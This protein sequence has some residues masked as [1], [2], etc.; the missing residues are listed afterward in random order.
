[1]DSP[2]IDLDTE[3]IDIHGKLSHLDAIDMR[4]LTLAQRY[5][6]I[7]LSGPWISDD[8]GRFTTLPGALPLLPALSRRAAMAALTA[9]EKGGLLKTWTIA[10]TK[11]WEVAGAYAF[12]RGLK[13]AKEER[14]QMAIR[15][16]KEREKRKK[17]KEDG[18]LYVPSKT[19]N[20]RGSHILIQTSRGNMTPLRQS[21]W[22]RSSVPLPKGLQRNR[23][24][25]NQPNDP[26]QCNLRLL[27]SFNPAEGLTALGAVIRH[28]L[29]MESDDYGRVRLDVHLLYDQLGRAI[30]KRNVSLETIQAELD[31][32][33]RAGYLK[34]VVKSQGRRFSFIRDSAQHLMKKKRSK[35]GIPKLMDDR[36]FTH[37][38][39]AYLAFY[40][41]CEELSISNDLVYVKTTTQGRKEMHVFEYL[42]WPRSGSWRNTTN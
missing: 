40:K 42:R 9:L 28:Y 20:S 4:E 7:T 36:E 21:L 8:Y 14:R 22:Y 11:C 37:D 26:D 3:N 34:V 32:M 31:S 10:G 33:A 17:C 18:T 27:P 41:S 29:L 12:K 30:T 15:R 38:T 23:M 13:E 25:K 6:L 5:A 35:P 19:R 1:M 24:I 39:E 2:Y 16:Q